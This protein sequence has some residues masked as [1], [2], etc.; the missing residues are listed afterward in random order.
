MSLLHYKV[1]VRKPNCKPRVEFIKIN[2]N[3]DVSIRQQV[4]NYC[5]G[6]NI[7]LCET[8]MRLT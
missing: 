1:Q 5:K 8:K 6:R 4:L 7:I 3:I 2:T